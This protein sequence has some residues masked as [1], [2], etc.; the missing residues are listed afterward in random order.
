MRKSLSA[1]ISC[2]ALVGYWLS[3]CTFKEPVLPA[4]ETTFRVPFVVENYVLGEEWTDEDEIIIKDSTSQVLW[5]SFRDSLKLNTITEED[6]SIQPDN[7]NRTSAIDTLEIDQLDALVAPEITLRRLIPALGQRVGQTVV[8]PD[9]TVPGFQ[10]IPAEKFKRAFFLNGVVRMKVTNNLPVTVGPNGSSAG[11]LLSVVS[12]SLPNDPFAEFLFDQPLVPGAE[13]IR[14]VEV[15][16]RWLYAPLRLVYELPVSQSAPIQITNDL[17]DNF[18][19]QVEVTLENVQSSEV[20]AIIDPQEYRDSLRIAYDDETRVREA[21][22][23]R[24]RVQLR[25]ANTVQLSA[26]LQIT[27]PAFRDAQNQPYTTTFLVPSQNTTVHELVL[28]GYNVI[29][30]ENPGELIDSLEIYFYAQTRASGDFVTVRSSDS[31]TVELINE[32]LVFESLDG[33]I[34]E[35]VF[36]IEPQV[37]A[38]I[39]DYQGFDGG[40]TAQQAVLDIQVFSEMFVENLL[41]DLRIVGIHKND[42]GVPVDSVIID[43]TDEQI[44]GGERGNPGITN[45]TLTSAQYP[46]V[47]DMLNLLPTDFRF[48]GEIR[49][50][51]DIAV[52]TDS[53][54]WA[55]YAFE[56][57]LRLEISG[58]DTYESDVDSLTSENIDQEISDLAEE[59]LLDAQLEFVA[60][61]RTPVAVNMKFVISA[62]AADTN[63]YDAE[64]D[65]S[66]TIIKEFEIPAGTIDPQTG[67]TTAAS[68]VDVALQLS[69][70]KIQLF[71]APPLRYGFVFS[72]ADTD[73][74]VTLRASD[75]VGMLGEMRITARIDDENP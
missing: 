69:Q 1:M 45:I 37:E 35:E 61:N 74:L 41:A 67:F 75:F 33:R 22:V 26:D 3:G 43:I 32:S 72:F 31:V 63:I 52:A 11:L 50:S 58:L 14:E 54:I 38:D 17:L 12:D 10:Q 13:V 44:A 6:F 16:D 24:G 4:W 57:P 48:S 5:F 15:S 62:D 70:Q 73:G 55:N 28:D 7:Y 49:A 39:V 51:G 42:A 21:E 20:V 47:L 9:T 8:L 60:T 36:E 68:Q 71:Q 66:L 56:T 27:M 30:P 34:N 40:V 25:I 64:Y 23:R 29:N 65:S 59:D 53:R 18:G 46:E 2:L 19:L